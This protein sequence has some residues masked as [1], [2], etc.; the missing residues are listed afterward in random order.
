M[1]YQKQL[2]EKYKDFNYVLNRPSI[3]FFLTNIEDLIGPEKNRFYLEAVFPPNCTSIYKI[4][5]LFILEKKCN[6]IRNNLKSYNNAHLG[7]FPQLRKH[8]NL[9]KKGR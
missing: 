5:P 9:T 6:M 7:V 4:A 3:V 8:I 2:L 1:I